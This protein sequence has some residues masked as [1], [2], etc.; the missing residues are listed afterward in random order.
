VS[1]QKRVGSKDEEEKEWNFK[2]MES[3]LTE[4]TS[5][6]SG[7]G[8]ILAAMIYQIDHNSKKASAKG[9]SSASPASGGSQNKLIK[10]EDAKS[11]TTVN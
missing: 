10:L 3:V 2:E 7:I 1:S 8:G 6:Q 11:S 5:K 9:V 4:I